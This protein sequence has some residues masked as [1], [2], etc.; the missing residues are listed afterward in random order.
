MSISLPNGFPLFSLYFAQDYPWC[1]LTLLQHVFPL[2]LK[3]IADR[4]FPLNELLFYK[5]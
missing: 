5:L 3:I 1:Q 4:S 2:P